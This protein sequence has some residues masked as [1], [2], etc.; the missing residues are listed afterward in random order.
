VYNYYSVLTTYV[1]VLFHSVIKAETG[2]NKLWQRSIH[3]RTSF[4]EI[5]NK[6]QLHRTWCNALFCHTAKHNML[7]IRDGPYSSN[8]LCVSNNVS[9]YE[10]YHWIS[11]LTLY[12]IKPFQRSY[13]TL[14]NTAVALNTTL[15]DYLSLKQKF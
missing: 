7:C 13:R 14:I 4:S 1:T 8:F 5:H 2:N 9:V 11:M 15:D 6:A 10:Q 3:S 12:S